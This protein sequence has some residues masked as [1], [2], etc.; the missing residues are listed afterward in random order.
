MGVCRGWW[1]A[2]NPT[3][4]VAVVYQRDGC[5]PQVTVSGRSEYLGVDR[6]W[7]TMTFGPDW[8]TV[9]ATEQTTSFSVPPNTN[10]TVRVSCYA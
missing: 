6:S 8:K 7:D 9:P 10:Y 1:Q 3:F 5:L 4:L 2:A